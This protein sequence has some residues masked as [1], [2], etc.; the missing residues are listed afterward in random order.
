VRARN[1]AIALGLVS[2][3]AISA[4]GPTSVA[5][6]SGVEHPSAVVA[7]PT[8]T[9]SPVDLAKVWQ[10]IAPSAA[11]IDPLALSTAE[12]RAAD[13]GYVRSLVVVRDGALVDQRYFGGTR[14]DTLADIR[15]GTKSVV[16]ML[17][18]IATDEKIL[19]GPR[20]RLDELLRPPIADLSG[21]KAA[22]TVDDLLTMRSGFA[23]DE[24]TKAG[25]NAWALAPNQVDDLLQR[26]LASTPGTSFTYDSAAVHL[27]S[28]GLSRATNGS[29][30]AYAQRSLLRP[31]GIVVDA[32][33]T[34]NQG[35]NN[36][37]AGLS[38]RPSD[39][40]KLGQ[41]VLQHGASG[42]R[43]V[44]PAAWIDGMLASH[45]TVGARVGPLDRLRYGYLWW[46]GTVGGQEV[47][48]AWGYRGQFLFVV[49]GRDLVIVVTSVLDDPSIDPDREAAGAMDLIV[50]GV[51][52]GVH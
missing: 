41:L 11:G 47:E 51:L 33:E 14:A 20:E 28:V 1:L 22:I 3:L 16:A 23:W 40:A 39:Y 15:S 26:P 35:F 32:W 9:P 36:G 18:G 24:S 34:D 50:N 52:P 13:L 29:T 48:F 43:Q 42:A 46:L 4:C 30:E 17:V 2:C 27:L 49:P 12:T 44:V 38:L 19:E 8:P 31:L 21:P 5:T 6:P 25:Y 37:G 10:T 7:R 45:E